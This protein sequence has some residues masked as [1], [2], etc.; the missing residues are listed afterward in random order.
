MLEAYLTR[1]RLMFDNEQVSIMHR[2][3]FDA[4]AQMGTYDRE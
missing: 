1:S 2:C 3:L 4:Q